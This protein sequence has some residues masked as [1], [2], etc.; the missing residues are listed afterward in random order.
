MQPARARSFFF[1]NVIGTALKDISATA[2]I[3]IN[4][5][6]GDR[7]VTRFNKFS[8]ELLQ[9]IERDGRVVFYRSQF[10]APY[11]DYAMAF[12]TDRFPLPLPARVLGL[13][14]VLFII[15]VPC[16]FAALYNVG[17]R[18]DSYLAPDSGGHSYQ[19]CNGPL[20]TKLLRRHPGTLGYCTIS[21]ASSSITAY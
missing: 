17:A 14:I 16:T 15:L 18:N 5:V 4:V 3:G 11:E 1:E 21:S 20:G 12:F 6:Q 19:I 8:P 7:L 10:P 13:Q 2:I 9:A